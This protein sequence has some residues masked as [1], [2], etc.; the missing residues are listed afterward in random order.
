M[1]K[2]GS[3][4]RRSRRT[5]AAA[6]ATLSVGVAAVVT[7]PGS[8]LAGG[9]GHGSH[10]HGDQR[11]HGHGHGHGHGGGGGGGGPVYQD[12]RAPIP[13]RV[14]DLMSRMTLAEKIGQMTQAERAAVA[15]DATPVT[16][17]GLGSLLS[18]GG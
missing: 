10:G 9:D 16:N 18:G 4:V 3:K 13:E 14:S 8:A 7:A 11:G 5:I 2:Y 15:N 1:T 12:P 6:V 17:L